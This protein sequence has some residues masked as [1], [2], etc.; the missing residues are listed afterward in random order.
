MTSY[1]LRVLGASGDQGYL[2]HYDQYQGRSDTWVLSPLTG[3]ARV[4]DGPTDVEWLNAQSLQLEEY[5]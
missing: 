4:L 5:E 3:G 1:R 2:T